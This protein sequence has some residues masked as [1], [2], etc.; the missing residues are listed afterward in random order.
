MN[1]MQ[2]SPKPQAGFLSVNSSR[3]MEEV[4]AAIF[5]ARQFPRD[6]V[7]VERKLMAAC[8]RFSL[9]EQAMYAYPRGKE[10]VTGPSIRLAE[11]ILQVYGNASSGI[12]ELRQEE[13]ESIIQAYAWDCESNVRSEKIF[14][15]PHKRA[16]KQGTK[17]LTDPRDI[18]EMVAN[19]GSRRL[20]ACI[21]ALIPG[22]L[23]DMCV[24]RCEQTL[25]KGTGDPIAV[26]VGKMLAAFG[27]MGVTKEKLE[28]R[29]KHKLEAT[30]ETE[31]VQLAK[32]Y[33]SIRDGMAKPADFFE[34]AEA[35][36]ADDL[37]EKFA[38]KAEEAP[39]AESLSDIKTR[40]AKVFGVATRTNK[41]S[42]VWAFLGYPDAAPNIAAMNSTE[43][44]E[45]IELLKDGFP[46]EAT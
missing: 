17:A 37:N 35:P 21:L 27:E 12:R 30:T 42:E 2:S 29:L 40:F 11:A 3:E 36:K 28:A 6:L 24:E 16:T 44:L 13:G 46:P 5:L 8:S 32:M 18:Y 45:M 34:T 10:I 23:V 41:L 38:P 1:E 4:K 7:E 22:D 43:L 15:V 39:P 9:A 14:S 25:A 26:R 19:M 20:R 33:K 31:L